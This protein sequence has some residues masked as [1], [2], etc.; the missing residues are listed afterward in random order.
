MLDV[1]FP[2]S[3]TEARSRGFADG[4]SELVR[5]GGAIYHVNGQGSGYIAYHRA[6]DALSVHPDIN[7][8][9]G[10]NDVSAMAALDAF[11]TAGLDDSQLLVVSFGLE[12]DKIR[13]TLLQDGPLKACL[14]L[15]PELVGRACIDAALCAIQNVPLPDHILPPYAVLTADNLLDYYEYHEKDESWELQLDRAN[16]LPNVSPQYLLLSQGPSFAGVAN[17]GYVQNFSSHGYYRS[18]LRTMQSYARQKRLVVESIDASQDAA[19]EKHHLK[20]RIGVAAAQYSPRGR[21]DHPGRR[22]HRCNRWRAPCATAAI[23]P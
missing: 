22:G 9:M 20:S 21:H 6:A 3:S 4:L 2:G 10:V 7:V 12:D 15:F 11:R 13:E 5:R 1:G 14:A 19:Q 16:S 23:S 18:L 8:I 17:I